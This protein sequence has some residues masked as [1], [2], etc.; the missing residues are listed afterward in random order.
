MFAIFLAACSSKSYSPQAKFI[1]G[2]TKIDSA[3]AR[4]VLHNFSIENNLFFHD[5]SHKYPSGTKTLLAVAKGADG[6][7]VI[8][9]EA[10]EGDKLMVSIHCHEEC[11][12]W[13]EAY[14]SVQ[15]KFKERWEIAE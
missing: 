1:F 12:H 6:L 9:G 7:Q 3:E 11:Q 8:L 5:S 10:G 15:S 2:N 14:S 13:E 4:R